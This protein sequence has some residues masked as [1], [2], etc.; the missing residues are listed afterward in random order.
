MVCLHVLRG[1]K[2]WIQGYTPTE[3]G[4]SS[5]FSHVSPCQHVLFTNTISQIS[6][7]LPN[8]RLDLFYLCPFTGSIQMLKVAHN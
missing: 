6:S 2:C 8:P 4:F 5:S 7:T 3:L 1:D